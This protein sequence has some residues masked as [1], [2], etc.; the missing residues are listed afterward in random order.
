MKK[1]VTILGC[2]RWGSFHAWYQ[3]EI[4][5]NK[6]LMWGR[7]EDDCFKSIASQRTNNYL[8]LP[9]TIALETDLSAAL[10][11]SEYI[12]VAISAQGIK[13]LASNI[14]AIKPKNKTFIL[15]MKGICED[16]GER[17]SEVIASAVDKS[18]KVCVWVG[19]GH[20]QDF[21]SGQPN[22]MIIASDDRATAK[23]VATEFASDLIK[24]YIGNDL[25]GAEVGA[26]AKNVLGIAAGMLD[27][28]NATS[29]KGALMARGAYEVSRLISAM[30]GDKMTAYGLSHLGDFEATL[31]SC[32]S[33]NR[34][35]GEEFF[36]AWT[37]NRP[38]NCQ[39]LAEGIST[40]KAL[41]ILAR[42]H[43]VDMPICTVIYQMLHENKSPKE[44]LKELFLRQYNEE[45]RY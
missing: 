41:M 34:L 20:V 14:A 43:K 22:V 1:S 27:G 7:A 26:A 15:C 21:I 37:Q 12:L 8:N 18:N 31:F 6:T 2:G 13:D 36:R 29:L 32:N 28:A 11:H 16:T 25:I 3:A 17:L 5:K 10:N 19:P 44:G 42:R 24:L 45:F 33:H 39:V 40:S 9:D 30:G 4:L 35:Y 23:T 38:L